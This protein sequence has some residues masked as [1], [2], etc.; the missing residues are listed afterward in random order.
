MPA[1]LHMVSRLVASARGPRRRRHPAPA[2]ER[3]AGE[4]PVLVRCPR[5]VRALDFLCLHF[6][7]IAVG[8]AA[9]H[10]RAEAWQ[11]AVRLSGLPS[12][13]HRS[14]SRAGRNRHGAAA[15]RSTHRRPPRVAHGSAVLPSGP[16]HLAHGTPAIPRRTRSIPS[17][18]PRPPSWRGA[19]QPVTR[20]GF[21]AA[22]NSSNTV[23]SD[24]I[25]SRLESAARACA[26][27]TR[28]SAHAA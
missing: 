2:H 20:Q 24:S 10:A 25:E 9:R 19:R 8:L 3:L 16:G 6:D 17:P 21:E 4:H 1:L 22:R 27:P 12:P 28:P 26:E 14:G 15:H 18:G 5:R 13:D 11:N 23:S 7:E